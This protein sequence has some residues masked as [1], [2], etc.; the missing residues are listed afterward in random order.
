MGPAQLWLCPSPWFVESSPTNP[1][2][3]LGSTRV[4]LSSCLNQL[5]PVHGTFQTSVRSYRFCAQKTNG[6]DLRQDPLPFLPFQGMSEG[7]TTKHC[8]CS[9]CRE[10]I[11]LRR[12]PSIPEG[13]ILMKCSLGSCQQL[14]SAW[15]FFPKHCQCRNGTWKRQEICLVGF[16]KAQRV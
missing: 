16:P 5:Q 9:L 3:L 15:Y 13:F 2:G 12:T 14:L 8:T 7:T 4:K 6:L 10:A 1:F 11:A